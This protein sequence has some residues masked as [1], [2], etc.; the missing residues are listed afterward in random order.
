MELKA[1]T[2]VAK[3]SD[4]VYGFW[5]SLEPE[6]GAETKE[7]VYDAPGAGLAKVLAK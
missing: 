1:T 5:S 6:W 4:E 2:T 3:S 7:Q